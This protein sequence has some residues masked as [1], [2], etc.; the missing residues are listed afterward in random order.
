ME[1]QATKMH[2]R[3]S[4]ALELAKADTNIPK[5]IKSAIL[6]GRVSSRTG[7]KSAWLLTTSAL[8]LLDSVL[9]QKGQGKCDVFVGCSSGFRRLGI[10]TA[11]QLCGETL[12]VIKLPSTVLFGTMESTKT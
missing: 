6:T 3:R 12:T 1:A 5:G 4:S 2:H 10:S 8:L 9:A 7:T 11:H